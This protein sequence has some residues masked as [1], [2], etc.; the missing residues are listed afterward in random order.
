MSPSNVAVAVCQKTK[1]WHTTKFSL[2]N[3]GHLLL[4]CNLFKYAARSTVAVRP[5]G[6]RSMC[7]RSRYCTMNSTS[8]TRHQVYSSPAYEKIV[9]CYATVVQLENMAHDE[10]QQC[11]RWFLPTHGPL[12][13]R[14]IQQSN[15]PR[16][17]TAQQPILKMIKLSVNQLD[18]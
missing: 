3:I 11:R 13:V 12:S 5:C 10:R 15:P 18:E 16:A 8:S 9:Y 2:Y 7:T 4:S 1:P 14:H 6:D 17:S